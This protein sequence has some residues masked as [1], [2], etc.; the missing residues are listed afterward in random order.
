MRFNTE[1]V[2]Y[3]NRLEHDIVWFVND[4]EDVM[5][6]I[7]R[8]TDRKIKMARS[9]Y[10]RNKIKDVNESNLRAHN[11]VNSRCKSNI[12]TVLDKF[13]EIKK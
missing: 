7:D 6:G 9:F 8:P 4:V 10:I 5:L 12:L 11:N 1:V 2:E 13:E 3:C